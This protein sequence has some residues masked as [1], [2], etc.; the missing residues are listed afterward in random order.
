MCVLLEGKV[1]NTCIES[2][3]NVF[4][5]LLLYMCVLLERKVFN[6][7]IESLYNVFVYSIKIYC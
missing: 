1:F 4:V 6:T 5:L 7:C 3:Y 2:L